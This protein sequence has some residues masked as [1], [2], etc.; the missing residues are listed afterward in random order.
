MSLKHST[1]KQ[2]PRVKKWHK[3]KFEAMESSSE[4]TLTSHPNVEKCE[5]QE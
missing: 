5:E 3:G 2:I 4:Q 1:L